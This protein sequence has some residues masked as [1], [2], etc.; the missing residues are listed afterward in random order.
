MEFFGN[1]SYSQYLLH[2]VIGYPL[3]DYFVSGGGV[4]ERFLALMVSTVVTVGV[5]T[6]S[7]YIIE[8]TAINIGHEVSS[9]RC[10]ISKLNS[11]RD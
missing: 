4:I 7:F 6:L 9:L 2:T 11:K 3:I 5:A 10:G 8:K 1:I